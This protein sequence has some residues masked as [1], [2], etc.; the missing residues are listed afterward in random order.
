MSD[1]LFR[2][3]AALALASFI[4]TLPAQEVIIPDPGLNA[5]VRETLHKPTGPL[6]QPDLLNLTFLNAHDRNI[7]NLAGLETARNLSTLLLFSNHLTNY[8]LPTLTNLTSLNLNGNSLT[9]VAL[10][11]GMRSLFSLLIEGNP[12]AQ[13]TLPADLTSL[14]ELVL[15]DN[16]LSS[17]SL[18]ANLTGLGEVDLGF[19]LLTNLTLPGGLTNLD[20]LR[21]SGNPL[22]NFAMPTGLTRLTQLYLDQNQLTSFAL[23]TGVTNLHVLDLSFNLLT[24]VSLPSDLRNLIDLNLDN[25]GLTSFSL[26]ATL[27]G[28]G[29]LELRS[30]L[31]TNFDLP[32][33]MKALSLLDL[34]ENQLRSVH[35]PTSLGH[36]A[37]LR[38]SGNT[39]LTSLTLPVGMT[40]LSGVFLRSNGLTN[41]TLPPDLHQLTTLD[42]LGNPLASITLPAGL[43]NLANLILSGNQL[44]NLT[45]PPDMG[46]L[47]SLV[48]DGNPLTQLVLSEPEAA[49]LPGP[50]ATLENLG[51]PV[52]QYPLT[53]QLKK[54]LLLAGNAFRF[55]VTGP[56]G[57]YTILS[58][59]N[60]VDWDELGLSIIP[61]GSIFITDTFAQFAP[62]KFY[63]AR[64]QSQPADMVFIAPNTFRMGSPADEQDRSVDEGPQT[65]VTLTHGFWIGAHEVT[66][67]EYLA[68]TGTNPSE[69]PGDL[70]RAISS[71]T[72]IDATNYCALLTQR[73]IAA[74]RISSGSRYRL[75]TEAEWECAARAGTTTRFSFGDD[76]DYASV[77]HCAWFLDLAA[78]DLTVHP[79]GQKLP[80]P[81]GLYDM[82]GNVWEWCQDDYGPL[83]GGTQTNPTGPASVT[84]QNK[85]LRGG[86]YDYPNSSCRSASRIFRY[87]LWPDSDVGFRVV[88]VTE[89]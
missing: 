73:E 58:S 75:P 8:S 11:S 34:G 86:A 65:T 88:L 39:N 23:P 80:N 79:V 70:S 71:V 55:G 84:L 69:F 81:W 44:T 20:M 59:T 56:P 61:L 85:V 48:L 29:F 68:V 83:P 2:A 38:L 21:L 4:T 37:T 51:I 30:N 74:G 60:L 42:A 16:Q 25:N 87:P 6:T 64:L 40:N 19:N 32:A 54:E 50:I 43:T 47:N 22:T 82:H 28:L 9:N 62:L 76:P 45:L 31:L 1:I 52:Y 10:P 12:L 41:L 3:S 67:G 63:R 24:N 5:A 53:V 26:P 89:P 7:S 46:R 15:A 78:P 13:L 14:E 18:P 33:E 35:L 72:W 77:T 17:F 57:N 27:S 49:A 66:Q 36:L